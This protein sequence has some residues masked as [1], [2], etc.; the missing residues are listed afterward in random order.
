VST[1]VPAGLY[2]YNTK[3][4]Q[5]NVYHSEAASVMEAYLNALFGLFPVSFTVRSWIY[6]C[7]EVCLMAK[8]VDAR[9]ETG[10]KLQ[11]YARGDDRTM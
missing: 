1:S 2:I 11:L 4:S 10:H 7:R 9:V 6:G 8:D 3:R 5:Q